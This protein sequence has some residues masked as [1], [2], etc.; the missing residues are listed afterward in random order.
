M[1]D[2]PRI[3]RAYINR[4]VLACQEAGSQEYREDYPVAVSS[5]VPE[6]YDAD[7]C[8]RQIDEYRIWKVRLNSLSSLL[9]DS[10]TEAVLRRQ[11]AS[12]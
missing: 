6:Q 3:H 4:R 8:V 10:V 12:Q 9:S 7:A 11:L 5:A 1:T 2:T